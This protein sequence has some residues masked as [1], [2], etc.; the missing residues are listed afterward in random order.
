[1]PF[2][3]RRYVYCLHCF[4]LRSS[5]W[6]DTHKKKATFDLSQD[7][8]DK[9]ISM[10]PRYVQDITTEIEILNDSGK[11]FKSSL[12]QTENEPMLDMPESP[13]HPC[14]RPWEQLDSSDDSDS[15]DGDLDDADCD[16]GDICFKRLLECLT[17]CFDK[18]CFVHGTFDPTKFTSLWQSFFH[19]NENVINHLN[20]Y[21]FTLLKGKI[22]SFMM[23]KLFVML[24]LTKTQ[25]DTLNT[26]FKTRKYQKCPQLFV[27]YPKMPT[28]FVKYPKVPTKFVNT[29]KCPDLCD[30]KK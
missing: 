16:E 6:F 15:D 22:L 19:G 11:L 10:F 20:R 23:K 28:I 25:I 2:Q 3:T 29:Q 30:R 12:V 27:N 26:F 18:F 5:S 21:R 17:E 7:A 1:M 24:A 4:K 13:L 9:H 14:F 8:L